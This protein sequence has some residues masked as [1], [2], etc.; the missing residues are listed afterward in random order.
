MHRQGQTHSPLALNM[1]SFAAPLIL[2][3]DSNLMLEPDSDCSR[4]HMYIMSKISKHVIIVSWSHY[5]SVNSRVESEEKSSTRI[6]TERCV[7]IKN[8]NSGK[9]KQWANG[10]ISQVNLKFLPACARRVL[11]SLF[12]N[13]LAKLVKRHKSDVGHHKLAFYLSALG[14]KHEASSCNGT[15]TWSIRGYNLWI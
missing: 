12:N 1:P 5:F 15:I 11:K 13:A 4:H 3:N 14:P 7:R 10:T 9:L 6:C 8:K 2:G